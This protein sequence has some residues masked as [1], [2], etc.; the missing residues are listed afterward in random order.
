MDFSATLV[1]CCLNQFQWNCQKSVLLST[2]CSYSYDKIGWSWIIACRVSHTYNHSGFIWTYFLISLG[3]N[4]WSMPL[5]GPGVLLWLLGIEELHPCGSGLAWI[6]QYSERSKLSRF[7][8]YCSCTRAES[9]S[10]SFAAHRRCPKS[11]SKTEEDISWEA[12]C[13]TSVRCPKSATTH[14]HSTRNKHCLPFNGNMGCLG[15]GQET[16]HKETMLLLKKRQR[17]STDLTVFSKC[18]CG[19]VHEPRPSEATCKGVLAQLAPPTLLT[20]HALPLLLQQ[21]RVLTVPL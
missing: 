6:E 13:I 1:A 12:E 18:I 2:A 17:Q 11:W 14:K 15:K 3:N 9:S 5:C 8:P 4:F 7:S 20:P 21:Y 16:C 19:L 10:H